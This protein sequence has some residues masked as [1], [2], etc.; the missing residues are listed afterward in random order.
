M[1]IL[2]QL[3]RLNCFGS[4]ALF[5]AIALVATVASG[6]GDP[7]G[8]GAIQQ[9]TVRSSAQSCPDSPSERFDLP[10]LRVASND[11]LCFRTGVKGGAR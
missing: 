3:S 8:D 2:M 7:S 10:V 5:A 11:A 9:N 4:S 6:G 1:S